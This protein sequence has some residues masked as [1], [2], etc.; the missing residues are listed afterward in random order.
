M[1]EYLTGLKTLLDCFVAVKTNILPG[2]SARSHNFLEVVEP[3]YKALEPLVDDY[4]VLLRNSYDEI[5]DA[6]GNPELTKLAVRHLV[7]ARERM[8]NTRISVRE[9]A[10]VL[11][12]EIHDAHTAKFFREVAHVFSAHEKKVDFTG[13]RSG[14]K[15]IVDLAQTL[16]SSDQGSGW[17]V[18]ELIERSIQRM[19][20]N[21]VQLNRTYAQLRVEHKCRQTWKEHRRLTPE[22]IEA[23]QRSE[24]NGRSVEDWYKGSQIAL[25]ESFREPQ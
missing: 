25:R 15:H 19:E 8:L 14:A 5:K 3:T 22:E 9:Q 6:D 11:A 21:W 13:N 18:L 7:R 4:L 20:Q 2:R 23:L 1:I 12:E 24:F 10:A 17:E 16:L